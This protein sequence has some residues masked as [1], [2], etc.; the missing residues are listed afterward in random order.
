MN[1]LWALTSEEVAWAEWDGESVCYIESSGEV[2]YLNAIA[3]EIIKLLKNHTH[4][5]HAAILKQLTE[6][7][8]CQINPDTL[9]HYLAK[10]SQ[11]HIITKHAAL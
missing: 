3:T 10:L 11:C 7:S 9:T 2:H 1:T 5:T 6:H 8:N 4:R